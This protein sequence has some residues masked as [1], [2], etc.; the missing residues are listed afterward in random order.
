MTFALPARNANGHA[1][2]HAT[3]PSD[4]TLSGRVGTLYVLGAIALTNGTTG[5]RSQGRIASRFT[6]GIR[7]RHGSNSIR[8][9]ACR[10]L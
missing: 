7:F 10:K 8:P 2:A 4:G 1:T 3:I 9:F 6:T 5:H